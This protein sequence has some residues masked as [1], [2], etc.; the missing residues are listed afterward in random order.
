[1]VSISWSPS[2]VLMPSFGSFTFFCIARRS[3][4]HRIDQGV[5]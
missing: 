4:V 5:I 2:R 3:F 1:L